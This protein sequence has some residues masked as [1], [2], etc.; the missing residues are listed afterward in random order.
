VEA[1]P[2][3]GEEPSVSLDLPLDAYLP[4]DYVPDAAV[5]LRLYQ[6]MAASLTP[7]QV[8][9]MAREM[10]DRFGPLPPPAANLLEVVR[11]KA[12]ALAAGVESIRSPEH[13][14]AIQTREERAIPQPTRLR[15][16]RKYGD[17]VKVTPH[18][19]RISR[20]RA[21]V[22]WKDIL[23]GVLEEMGEGEA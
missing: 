2:D 19:V 17:L 8:R 15:L 13:E 11:L 14:I 18:Q 9:D 12:L 10:Q 20:A 5:R 21:G 3:E 23:A 22:R 16:Q 6:R 1:P 7:V 4:E